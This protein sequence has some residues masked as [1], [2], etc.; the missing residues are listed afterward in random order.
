MEEF[1]VPAHVSEAANIAVDQHLKKNF[2]EMELYTDVL[3]SN[4][5]PSF[6]QTLAYARQQDLREKFLK[7]KESV[8]ETEGALCK[9]KLKM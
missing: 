3:N 7:S 1:S 4:R 2:P 5:D 6:A 8:V 9:Q